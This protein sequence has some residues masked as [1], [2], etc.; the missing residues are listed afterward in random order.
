VEEEKD[1]VFHPHLLNLHL[2]S[3]PVNYILEW[4]GLSL[5]LTE[6][7]AAIN[8]SYKEKARALLLLLPLHSANS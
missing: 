2:S 7:S 3:N 6:M 1:N 5:L 4:Q 8:D